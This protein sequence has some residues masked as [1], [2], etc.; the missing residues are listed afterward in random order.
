MILHNCTV[1][2]APNRSFI[3]FV[4]VAKMMQKNGH[5]N[6]RTE[7]NFVSILRV[8]NFDR[9]CGWCRTYENI[10]MQDCSLPLSF[11]QIVRRN[12]QKILYP[13][14]SSRN[15]YIFLIFEFEA[16]H[17]WWTGKILQYFIRSLSD[18]TLFYFH[19]FGRMRLVDWI[20]M[21][22]LYVFCVFIRCVGV[23][24]SVFQCISVYFSILQ[25]VSVAERCQIESK[26]CVFVNMCY[27][28]YI[29]NIHGLFVWVWS[30]KCV[31]IWYVAIR[32]PNSISLLSVTNKISSRQWNCV[33]TDIRLHILFHMYIYV[34]AFWKYKI[35]IQ[36]YELHIWK[37]NERIYRMLEP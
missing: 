1:P 2:P 10:R 23:C 16:R 9:E 11:S 28:E 14:L 15:S 17:E 6:Q 31:E 8:T 36:K 26:L 24:L 7:Y 34:Y 13:S 30:C 19:L 25:S 35:Y 18:T 37:Q 12:S 21:G 27:F 3:I 33:R 20:W 4:W 22:A 29:T 32:C 5:K